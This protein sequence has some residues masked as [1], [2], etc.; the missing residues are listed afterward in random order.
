MNRIS[1]NKLRELYNQISE[2]RIIKPRLKKGIFNYLN[3][4]IHISRDERDFDLTNYKLFRSLISSNQLDLREIKNNKSKKIYE[5]YFCNFKEFN[6]L[7]SKDIPFLFL[8]DILKFI[9]QMFDTIIILIIS[10]ISSFKNSFKIILFGKNKLIRKKIHSIYYWE[11]RD[12]SALYYYPSIF[13]D[14]NNLIFVS[15]F[16]DSKKFLFLGLLGSLRNSKYIS[17]VKNLDIKSLILSLFQFIHLY[18]NDL[19]LVFTN[20]DCSFLKFWYGWKKCSEIFYSILIYNSIFELVKNSYECEF[21]S[22]H[23]NQVSNRAF[24]LAVSNA[25]KKF[26]CKSTLSTYNGSPISQRNKRQFFPTKDELRIGFWGK[27]YYVQDKESKYELASYLNKKKIKID[28]Q[29][30][31][32]NMIR[33][34][35][36]KFEGFKKVKLIREITIFTH[37]SYWD[38]LACLS[39]VIN[40]RNDFHKKNCSTIK[41]NNLIYIRLHPCL[42]KKEA[43]KRIL[44]MQ[45]ISTNYRFEFISNNSESIMDSIKKSSFC[46]FGLSSYINLAISLNSNVISVDTN[47][48]DK[49]PINSKF[50]STRKFLVSNPW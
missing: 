45:E 14:S 47:H 40:F 25:I 3:L 7:L 1:I 48:I 39:G 16:A 24:S 49:S 5:D 18:L 21:I 9:K 36:D 46:F 34:Q 8:I 32:E 23:E 31:P 37:D 38:L 4:S 15:S 26:N 11:K 20:K 50:L 10:T 19:S 6:Y 13:D 27:K 42:I 44:S 12:N 41:E 22:W 17:P 30:V 35:N 43:L 28:L 2:K 29:I 33:I